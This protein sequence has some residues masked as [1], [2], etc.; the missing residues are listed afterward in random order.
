VKDMQAVL[1]L[2]WDKLTPALKTSPLAADEDARKKLQEKLKGLSLRPQEGS[3]SAAKVL[4]K[5]FEFSANDR[6]LESI[7]LESDEKDSAVIL[8]ARFDGVEHRIVCGRGAW[9]KGRSAWGALATQPVAA[10][11][12]WTEDDTFTAKL[13]FY[14]TPFI[15]TTRLKFSADEVRCDVESNVGFGPLKQAQLIGKAK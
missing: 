5:K 6:K 11:G 4:G 1:N 3:A 2:I 15:F 12:A 9:R 13:C 8:V 14:E 10:S 7:T